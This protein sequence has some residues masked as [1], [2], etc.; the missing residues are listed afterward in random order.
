MELLQQLNK[1]QQKAVI[2]K[3]GPLLLLAGAGSG[4]TRVLTH[5][6][7]YLIQE[8]V[9]PWNILA[10]TFT[11]KAAK[12]MRE[13]VNSIIENGA[14][15]VWVST[16]HSM[17][18]RM[19]RRD[20]EKI[21]Y[22]KSFSIYDSSDQERL[23]KEC[24]T[25]LNYSDKLFTPKGV[26]A[27]ISSLKNELITYKQYEK[28]S[29]SDF[30]QS[31]VAKIYTMYQNKLRNNNA[32]DFDDLI[33]KTID[34][35]RE[36]PEVLDLYQE[37][38]KYIMVDEYQDTNT[39]QYQLIRMLAAKYENLCVVGDDDQSIYGWRGANIRN[40]LDFEKDFPGATTIKLEQN[41]R[42][43][44]NILNAA[45]AVIG[46]NKSRK[47]KALWT[48]NVEGSGLEVVKVANQFEEGTFVADEIKRLVKAEDKNYSDFALL[49]RTNAQSRILEEKLVQASIPYRLLGGTRFYDRKEIKDIMSYLKALNNPA[50]DLTI[51]RII[52]VPKRGIGDT[53][54]NRV[55]DIAYEQDVDFFKVL[56]MADEIAELGRS[57]KKLKD[58]ANFIGLLSY[59]VTENGV[60]KLI[61]IVMER[62]GY[63]KE[64]EVEG[65]EEAK[66]RIENLM[67]LVSKATEYQKGA[68]EPS[69]SGFLEEVALVADV[70]NYEQS[71]NTVVLMTLHSAKG[72]E[73]PYVFM[74][75]M[76]E[77]V[78]PSYRSMVSGNENDVEEE[79][80]L[81]YVGITRAREQLYLLHAQSRMLNGNT[82]Y[83]Q[84][85][86]FLREIPVDLIGN[87]KKSALDKIMEAQKGIEAPKR[88]KTEKNMYRPQFE[89][90]KPYQSVLASN[91]PAP[92]GIDLDFSQG[93]RIKHAKFG[94]GTVKEIKPAGADY[95]I[96]IEFDRVGEKKMMSTFAKLTKI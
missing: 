81:C 35:F 42:S 57:A 77:G 13:R 3:D 27:E 50:D 16:F 80:R 9:K 54:I 19:L 88:G 61:E 78:F 87:N 33:F 21:G 5:R 11:N 89:K 38:F 53:T 6:I 94:E 60:D 34:L 47:P 79:R 76:E 91:I 17:C 71:A 58:F 74:T 29:E 68:E 82:Q 26:M 46:N 15:D 96:L 70:D 44:Q 51:K 86:R 93:D 67:E 7:A 4:K 95:E 62:T 72:L 23:V 66:G 73:F 56:T 1:E 55:A 22:E 36:V 40:I 28:I 8:G 63:I 59:E 69:L 64:L 43:T 12:E 30:R 10:I 14:E 37:K 83:N 18:V 41:Y 49:Y 2:H 92:K 48:Q 85:S 65:T 32:L 45:N 52:N 84:P 39:A 20:I 31:K 25:T 24:L 90:T 75:G